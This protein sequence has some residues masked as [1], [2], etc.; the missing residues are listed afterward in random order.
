MLHLREDRCLRSVDSRAVSFPL[1]PGSWRLRLDPPGIYFGW[2]DTVSNSGTLDLLYEKTIRNNMNRAG[3]RE[4]VSSGKAGNP[5]GHIR[6]EKRQLY[7][8]LIGNY[9]EGAPSLNT[10]LESITPKAPRDKT[11]RDFVVP[12]WRDKL[13]QPG[14]GASLIGNWR[15]ISSR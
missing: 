15:T 1:A 7:D 14:H 11:L 3:P 5:T 2:K 6:A 13:W 9:F 12:R 8:R 10:K 4:K